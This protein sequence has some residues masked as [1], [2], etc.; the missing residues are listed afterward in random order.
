VV[1]GVAALGWGWD[2]ARTAR[3]YYLPNHN[4]DIY[5]GW[6][7]HD[8]LNTD[9]VFTFAGLILL[10]LGLLLTRPAGSRPADTQPRQTS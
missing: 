9:L 4:P 10:A 5:T 2:A 6:F 7:T 3:Y 8:R 1:G